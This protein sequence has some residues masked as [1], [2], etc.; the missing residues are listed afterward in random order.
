MCDTTVGAVVFGN[1]ERGEKY[2]YFCVRQA[3][4]YLMACKH[5]CWALTVSAGYSNTQPYDFRADPLKVTSTYL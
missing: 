1:A 5:S 2:W 3:V 4:H